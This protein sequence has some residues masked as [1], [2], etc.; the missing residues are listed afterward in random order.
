[1]K[2]IRIEDNLYILKKLIPKDQ[3]LT[4]NNE[5]DRDFVKE[6]TSYIRVD[7]FLEDEYYFL[8]LNIIEPIDFEEIEDEG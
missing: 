1:M 3:F 2:L 6:Y 5:I 8:F 4:K 7:T